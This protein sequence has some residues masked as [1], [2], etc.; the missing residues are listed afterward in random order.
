MTLTPVAYHYVVVLP[1][2]VLKTLKVC[3]DRGSIP[4][5]PHARQTLYNYVIAGVP[6]AEGD[7]KNNVFSI[8][9]LQ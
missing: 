9:H 2:P 4:D 5:L 6:P 3:P 1:L 7:E 8:P